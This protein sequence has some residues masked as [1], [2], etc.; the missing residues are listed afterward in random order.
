VPASFEF[1]YVGPSKIA[2]G[3][4][5]KDPSYGDCSLLS[6][7]T[8]AWTPPAQPSG[9]PCSLDGSVVGLGGLLVVQLLTRV[10]GGV[11][12]AC[13]W[14]HEISR[15]HRGSPIYCPRQ[16][17]AACSANTQL[18][19]FNFFKDRP[20]YPIPFLDHRNRQ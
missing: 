18:S 12:T 13:A 6:R 19:T 20:A 8:T 10:G 9:S 4:W 11:N 1:T 3:N 15:I 16:E 5:S 2:E 14:I 7:L 17:G